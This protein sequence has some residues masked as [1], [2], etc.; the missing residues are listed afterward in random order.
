VVGEVDL[1]QAQ[2]V[3]GALDLG[4]GVHGGGVTGGACTRSDPT[5]RHGGGSARPRIASSS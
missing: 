4:G 5:R 3:S 2:L 1:L